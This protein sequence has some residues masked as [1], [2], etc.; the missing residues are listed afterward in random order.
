MLTEQTMDKLNAMKLFG[1]AKAF[2]D[3]NAATKKTE[4]TPEDF[5]GFLATP[6]GSIERVA[7]CRYG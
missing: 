3:W 1:M 7:S 4:V 2:R 6:N 5:V